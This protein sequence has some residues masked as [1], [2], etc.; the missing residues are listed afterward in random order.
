MTTHGIDL[1]DKDN[2]GRMLLGLFE[3]VTNTGCTHTDKHLN[4][5]GAGDSKERN[6]R[7]TSN[8]LGQQCLTSTWRANHQYALRNLPSQF[9]E[10]ARITQKVDQ[11]G[12]ILLGLLY[13]GN[14]GKSDLNLVLA[15]HAR[16]ALT[17]GHSTTASTATLHLA[18]EEYPDT[19]QQQHGEPGDEYLHQY[20]LLFRR[21]GVHGNAA[22][23]QVSDKTRIIWRVGYKSLTI[24]HKTTNASA[25]DIYP[26][27]SSLLNVS[28]K[29]RVFKWL[30]GWSFCSKVVE[31][32]HQND[33][34]NHPE[35][36]VFCYIVQ[37]NSRLQIN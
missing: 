36:D 18:H 1:I 37:C 8:S 9:L 24:V 35:N 10:L 12:D 29:L 15:E 23:K 34:N 5:V 26:L 32:R 28:N 2:T 30:A 7:L 31:N 20:S 27:H 16:L 13:T 6:F 17:E 11:L 3:H 4:E 22:I 21:L 25:L 33:G 14:I 19:D